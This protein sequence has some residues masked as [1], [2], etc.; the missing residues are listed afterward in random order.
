MPSSTATGPSPGL[1]P[2][3]SGPRVLS[4]NSKPPMN[5]SKNSGV[6]RECAGI[7]YRG[8]G[9]SC[10]LSTRTPRFPQLIINAEPG[11]NQAVAPGKSSGQKRDFT[12][13]Q[14]LNLDKLQGF[15]PEFLN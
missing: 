8:A 14:S 5:W 11:V 1:I 9:S 12:A 15:W 2:A 13:G 10:L 6:I 3:A 7:W 4:E